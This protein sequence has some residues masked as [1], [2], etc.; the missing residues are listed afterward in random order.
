MSTSVLVTWADQSGI[1]PD[2]SERPS[3]C[4]WEHPGVDAGLKHDN[5]G[6]LLSRMRKWIEIAEKPGT[7]TTFLALPLY[8]TRHFN[9]EAMHLYVKGR[10]IFFPN[11]VFCLMV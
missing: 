10:S 1:F 2:L 7:G 3:E 6:A 8:L 11:E 4:E 9:S 5:A